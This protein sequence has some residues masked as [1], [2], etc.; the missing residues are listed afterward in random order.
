MIRRQKPAQLPLPTSA[1]GKPPPP[2]TSV[3]TL[4]GLATWW[5]YDH[6]SHRLSPAGRRAYRSALRHWGCE[7]VDQ[8]LGLPIRWRQVGPP[9]VMQH[10]AVEA[11]MGAQLLQGYAPGSVVSWFLRVKSV[12]IAGGHAARNLDVFHVL[13]RVKRPKLAESRPRCPPRDALRRFLAVAAHPA[14]EACIRAVFEGCRP[15]ESRAL[16]LGDVDQRARVVT[17]SRSAGR[18][19]RK[20]GGRHPIHCSTALWAAIEWTIEHHATL[21]PARGPSVS[22]ERLFPFASAAWEVELIG[23]IRDALGMDAD[24][25]LPPGTGLYALRHLG[26]TLTAEA[27]GGDVQAVARY[28]GDRSLTA[29][30]G[31]CEALRGARSAPVDVLQ[32]IADAADAADP[33]PVARTPAPRSR[34]AKGATVTPIRPALPPP[35]KSTPAPASEVAGSAPANIRSATPRLAAKRSRLPSDQ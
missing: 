14:E 29:A 11:Y 18:D 5:E 21:Y 25:Y 2:H 26:A 35:R 34:E 3:H 4:A 10:A 1:G 32:A 15:G 17:A 31:Y 22:D 13:A 8:G 23:R 20:R 16:Q 12:A 30:M 28:L 7:P 6:V 19:T 33:A 24:R 9:D 27:T